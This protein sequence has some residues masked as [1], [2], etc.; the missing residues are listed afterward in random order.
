MQKPAK[1]NLSG[2]VRRKAISKTG[3]SSAPARGAAQNPSNN[4]QRL[5]AARPQRKSQRRRQCLHSH[6]AWGRFHRID[7]VHK[8]SPPSPKALGR[9]RQVA[10]PC[11]VGWGACPKNGIV[12]V[13]RG[14]S[15]LQAP[16]QNETEAFGMLHSMDVREIPEGHVQDH[17]TCITPIS[18]H[19][20]KGAVSSNCA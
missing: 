11:T 13:G 8:A 5:V 2:H 4:L 19:L 16:R 20:P 6:L 17:G 15:K 14:R 10:S 9:L 18:D 7:E 12:G 3:L 1:Y